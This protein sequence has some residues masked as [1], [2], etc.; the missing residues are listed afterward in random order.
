MI[1]S[2]A[3]RLTL[4]LQ[5]NI[6]DLVRSL[7]ADQSLSAKVIRM[8]NSPLY[9]RLQ[10]VASLDQAIA[11]LGFSQLKSVIITATTFRMFE[12]SEHAAVANDLW[13]HSLS[14][15]IGARII[16][17]KYGQVD[18]EEAYLAGL[19][20]DIGK[21]VLLRMTPN[22]YEEII[23][24]VKSTEESF[25]QVENRDLGFDHADI[26]HA[27]LTEWEFPPSIVSAVAD[28]H[29]SRIHERPRSVELGRVVCLA[30]SI[31]RYNGASF[32]EP[33]KHCDG[34]DIFVGPTKVLED[35]LISLRLE[36]EE[37]FNSELNHIYQ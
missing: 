4:D 20:H 13:R 22:A 17:K 18:K 11:V 8:S 15:A 28:H 21:L 19:L 26:G 31:S 29:C 16:A 32:Y 37:Q 34:G 33:Y 27:L 36:T 5:S 12:R 7:L 10:R 30:D 14:T 24:T 1:L 3:L 9:A 23:E 35:D 6:S 25:Q 2:R